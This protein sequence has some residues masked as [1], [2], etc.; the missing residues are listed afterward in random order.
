M[1]EIQVPIEAKHVHP[2]PGTPR[3]KDNHVALTTTGSV[4]TVGERINRIGRRRR[5]EE[6]QQADE[7]H[8]R[9]GHEDRLSQPAHLLGQVLAV[10]L[11][12][13]VA[14][15]AA[16]LRRR[17][18]VW[19]IRGEELGGGRGSVADLAGCGGGEGVGGRVLVSGLQIVG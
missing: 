9:G 14:V 4:F 5:A 8:E 18:L 12:A 13:A 2:A 6:R 10:V 16:A 1:N 3:I 19:L 11:P 15:V 7:E 17:H